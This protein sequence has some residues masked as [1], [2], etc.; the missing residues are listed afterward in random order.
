M[1]TLGLVPYNGKL[2]KEKD[3]VPSSIKADREKAK[4][5]KDNYKDNIG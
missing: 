3:Y 4:K 5:K 1:R 2:V